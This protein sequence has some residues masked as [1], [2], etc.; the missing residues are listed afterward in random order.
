MAVR[1]IDVGPNVDQE[2]HNAVVGPTDG[3]VQGGDALVVRLA[4][5]IQLGQE[6]GR[7][8]SKAE[9]TGLQNGHTNSWDRFAQKPSLV[10]PPHQFISPP[11]PLQ[12]SWCSELGGLLAVRM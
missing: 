10:V 5:V 6:R 3:I 7:E 8:P 11:P 12:S 9:H 4:R 2:V 1:R